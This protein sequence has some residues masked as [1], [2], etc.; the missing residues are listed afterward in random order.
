MEILPQS[1]STSFPGVVISGD[2]I[3]ADQVKTCDFATVGG[4]DEA[5]SAPLV[6]SSEA[7]AS[8]LPQALQT[9]LRLT[10]EIALQGSEEGSCRTF[11]EKAGSSYLVS[12][13]LG[14]HSD[15]ALLQVDSALI[16]PIVDRLLGGSGEPSELSREVTD[17]EDQIAKDFVR[18]V[19]QELQLAWRAFNVSVSIGARQDSAQLQTAF[20][21]NDNA[22]VFN[23][24]VT[25]QSASGGLQ[26]MLPMASL[27]SFLGSKTVSIREASRRG[28]MNARF[29]EK[30]LDWSFALELSLVGGKVSATD[31]LN[32]CVGKIL[33][34]GVSVR[35]PGV[36]RIGGHDAFRAVPVRSGKHRGA[37]LLDRVPK[38]QPET[39]NTL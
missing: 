38:S 24:A 18:V 22:L 15:I 35:T 31:L 27:G 7:L 32:L 10:C 8:S 26:L 6:K 16:F 28:T 14:A 12:L 21:A 5:R 17:I 34:L 33:P 4:I 3:S 37:Q 11:V 9:K 36:L 30:S 1:A 13:E 2:S 19:C 25:M 20:S 23:F 29:V 39:G